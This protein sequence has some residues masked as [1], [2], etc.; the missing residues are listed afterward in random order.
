MKYTAFLGLIVTMFFIT[1]CA[2]AQNGTSGSTASSTALVTTDVILA[3]PLPNTVVSSPLT[4]KGKARGTW[5]FEAS[6]PVALLDVEGNEI[7]IAPAQAKGE[8]MTTD[9][10]EFETV[11]TFQTDTESGFLVVRK[12]NPSGLPEN[13]AE[14]RMPIRFSN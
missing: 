8:W 9:F 2:P 14:V 12:D 11:L 10:V 1:A 3:T 5:F 6:L 4:V 7:A 13:D